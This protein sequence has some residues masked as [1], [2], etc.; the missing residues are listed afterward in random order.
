MESPEYK[1]K[2]KIVLGDFNFNLNES[3]NIWPEKRFLNEMEL[4]DS[5]INAINQD[6]GDSEVDKLESGLTENTKKNSMRFNSK[7]EHKMYRYDAILYSKEKLKVKSSN[8]IANNSILLTGDKLY[9]NDYY[10]KV[11]ISPVHLLNPQLITFGNYLQDGKTK[12]IY[13]LFIS[14]HFGVKSNFIIEDI[15]V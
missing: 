6:L 8:I 7:F 12:N 11:I 2:A 10:E 15:L 9:L 14:D 3:E 5:W 4:S 1:L 13:E